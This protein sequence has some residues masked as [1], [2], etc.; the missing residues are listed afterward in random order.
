MAEYATGDYTN[1]FNDED[2][3]ESSEPEEKD[4]FESRS[5]ARRCSSLIEEFPVSGNASAEESDRVPPEHS[6]HASTDNTMATFGDRP[7]H[8]LHKRDSVGSI[9]VLPANIADPASDS[10]DDDLFGKHTV[11][12]SVK[13]HFGLA[14]ESQATFQGG[15]SMTPA[16]H[17]DP[18]FSGVSNEKCT[19][20]RFLVSMYEKLTADVDGNHPWNQLSQSDRQKAI[21]MYYLKHGYRENLT[22]QAI[23]AGLSQHAPV[24]EDDYDDEDEDV[25]QFDD[26][27]DEVETAVI[28]T[29]SMDETYDEEEAART[30]RVVNIPGDASNDELREFFETAGDILR[31]NVDRDPETG[32]CIGTASIQFETAEAAFNTVGEFGV[33]EFRGVQLGV[34]VAEA[35]TIEEPEIVAQR[36][37]RV[38]NLPPFCTDE[39]IRALFGRFGEI[40]SLSVPRDPNSGM[41]LGT[42]FVEFTTKESAEK[43]AEEDGAL[44]LKG[45]TLDL[46]IAEHSLLETARRTVLVSNL[47]ADCSDD[48]LW[49]YFSQFG[50]VLSLTVPRDPE[51]GNCL[52]YA[53]V[54]FADKAAADAL[55]KE[56]FAEW[57]GQTI[58]FSHAEATA[59]DLAQRSIHV[60]NVPAECTDQELRAFFQGMGEVVRLTVPRDAKGRGLGY[61]FVEFKDR[62]SAYEAANEIGTGEFNGATMTF[63][64]AE[65]FSRERIERSIQV[66]SLPENADDGE[67]L[68]FF[69]EYGSVIRVDV[70]RD[71]ET[72]SCLGT[73]TVEFADKSAAL[74]V[75]NGVSSSEF[76]GANVR[77]ALV[78]GSMDPSQR[79][80][81][82]KGS[83]DGSGSEYGS[84]ED[85]SS[86]RGEGQTKKKRRRKKKKKQLT[87][88]EQMAA[89]A[90]LIEGA[91]IDSDDLAAAMHCD[92]LTVSKKY[93]EA[94]EIMASGIDKWIK[95][96]KA[97]MLWRAA[98]C[99]MLAAEDHPDER[100]KQISQLKQALEIAYSA[101]TIAPNHPQVLK[102][103]GMINLKLYQVMSLKKSP[104]FNF[105]L[106]TKNFLKRCQTLLPGD[107]EVLRTI[108]ILLFVAAGGKSDPRRK[109]KIGR[110]LR[111]MSSTMHFKPAV[112]YLKKSHKIEHSVETC[113]YMGKCCQYFKHPENAR[114]WYQ[115]ASKLDPHHKTEVIIAQIS[116][117][118]LEKI[119]DIK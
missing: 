65:S 112:K 28:V 75:A 109:D 80:R 17:R 38:G 10:D 41:C 104:P 97:D 66:S 86:S 117:D 93:D 24:I 33:V 94:L 74:E 116:M 48:E 8:F 91:Q 25:I 103:C 77:F 59:L 60:R 31:M 37:V 85:S 68:S 51:T 21:Q 96:R 36:T 12:E 89:G 106:E 61:A 90:E 11:A 4:F 27:E 30:I 58:T 87:T 113:Y 105:L 92:Q 55:T 46:S 69:G 101:E 78:S 99:Y 56:A 81:N 98:R 100:K 54:E 5:R 34:A 45:Y 3:L 20:V 111:K 7:S 2:F 119:K 102:Y 84:D 50:E 95:D 114:A 52:G 43:L 70:A 76:N 35:S 108:G 62:E 32:L 19:G 14:E 49:D 42:A 40:K 6:E 26:G 82:K 67:L 71:N 16:N 72:G 47:P 88:A 79:L 53:F 39:E 15:P 22:Q 63:A 13:V 107:A 110:F 23:L 9:P 64:L 1:T 44:E 118:L 29:C 18:N 83:G 57:N 115:L 73:A